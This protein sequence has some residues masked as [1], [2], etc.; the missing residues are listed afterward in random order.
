MPW[1][2][3]TVVQ[4]RR[5]FVK[6]V[7]AA[8]LSFTV[9]SLLWFLSPRIYGFHRREATSFSEKCIFLRKCRMTRDSC[10]HG[11]RHP[12]EPYANFTDSGGI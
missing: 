1:K 4:T 10:R 6:R 11:A 2:G 8:V 7:C 9:A 12:P 3:E 5:D